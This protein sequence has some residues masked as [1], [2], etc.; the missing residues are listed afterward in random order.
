MRLG[1]I[2]LAAV[3]AVAVAASGAC[4]PRATPQSAPVDEEM[5]VYE[6]ETG[7]PMLPFTEW[8]DEAHLAAADLAARLDVSANAVEVVQ[9][10][11]QEMP[12]ADL[13]C[14]TLPSK[15]TAEP[16][17]I[18]LGKEVVLRCGGET[19]VYHVHGRRVVLCEGPALTS[20]GDAAKLP[21][22]SEVALEAA[23]EDLAA[24]LRLDRDAIQV[25]SV[26]KRM[27]NDASLGCPEPGKM[28]AQVITPGFLVRLEAEGATYEYHTSLTH[29]VL[30]EKQN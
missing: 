14:P 22:A 23:L 25:L 17:G 26:E 7:I 8:P 16:A 21:D 13:G 3:L 12:S 18:V 6:E 29:A 2:A 28:Y 10:S 1:H 4:A 27:W 9:V 20:A 24:R 5:P 11:T 19:Y 15:M 30:C